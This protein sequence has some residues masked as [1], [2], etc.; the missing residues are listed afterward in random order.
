MARIK[1]RGRQ[2]SVNKR[3]IQDNTPSPDPDV[4]DIEHAGLAAIFSLIIHAIVT[5]FRRLFKK[6]NKK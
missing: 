1:K 2:D 5:A 4:D 6:R 3:G